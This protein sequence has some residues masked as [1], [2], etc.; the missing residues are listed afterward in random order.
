MNAA[1]LRSVSGFPSADDPRLRV[2]ALLAIYLLLGITVLGF[3]RSPVQIL[4][5]VLATCA[6]DMLL[7]RAIK[8]RWLFPLSAAITGLS[9]AILVNY[10]HGLWLPLIPPFLAVASKYLLT[11]NGRHVYNPSL[12]GLVLAIWLGSEMISPAPA[13]QWGGYPAVAIFIVTAAVLM[14]A[15]KI[16]R[17]PLIVSFLIFYTINLAIRAWLMRWHVPPETLFFGTLSSPAFYLFAFFMITD[18]ATS[19]KTPRG[20]IAM[21]FGICTIDLFLQQ[22]G[23][24]EAVFKAAFL[25]STFMF[26]WQLTVALREAPHSWLPRLQTATRN[27]V[28]VGLIWAP[29]MLTHKLLSDTAVAGDTDFFLIAIIIVVQK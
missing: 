10:S 19:P 9:L 29:A 12:F 18:P 5:V 23:S 8:G 15:L 20:Q 16:R 17:T 7:H 14:F 4:I 2:L 25:V 28:L 22:Y 1:S 21:S 3:N 13:Y 24:F 27:A 6:L 26:L 11:V